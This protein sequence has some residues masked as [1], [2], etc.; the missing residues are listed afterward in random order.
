[1]SLT[2]QKRTANIKSMNQ[3]EAKIIIIKLMYSQAKKIIII[4]KLT[5]ATKQKKIITSK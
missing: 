1:M 2:E 3:I 5:N 4:I